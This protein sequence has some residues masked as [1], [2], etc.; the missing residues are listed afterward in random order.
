MSRDKFKSRSKYNLQFHGL[1]VKA[2]GILLYHIVDN[3]LFIL[4]SEKKIRNKK[5][6]NSDSEEYKIIWED[7]GGKVDSTDKTIYD[8]AVRETLEESNFIFN[9]EYLRAEIQKI[10]PQNFAWNADCCYGTFILPLQEKIDPTI[11]G[12]K[13]LHDNLDRVCKWVSYNDFMYYRKKIHIRL[14]TKKLWTI[15]YNLVHDI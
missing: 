4:V 13:E 12:E 11:L 15:L 1:Q 5:S 2:S 14:K 9:E 7:F 10:F 6:S 8:T 3:E